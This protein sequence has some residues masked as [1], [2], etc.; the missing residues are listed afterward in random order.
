[1]R[2]QRTREPM[3]AIHVV[4][5]RKGSRFVQRRAFVLPGR[6]RDAFAVFPGKSSLANVSQ[7]VNLAKSD[8]LVIDLRKMQ[9]R[10]CRV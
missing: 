2:N 10:R 3:P 8:F 7:D 5:S 4:S 6:R 9:V 1:S